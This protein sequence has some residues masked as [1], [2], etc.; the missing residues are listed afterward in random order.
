MKKEYT[1]KFDDIIVQCTS[2]Y[3]I[4]NIL[5]FII[6]LGTVVFVIYKYKG[7]KSLNNHKY[8]IFFTIMYLV[9]ITCIIRIFNDCN[10]KVTIVDSS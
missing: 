7:F 5:L 1:V 10:Q 6:Y 9:R 3:L 8:T 2:N 4:W